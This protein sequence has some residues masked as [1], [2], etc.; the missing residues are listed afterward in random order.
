MKELL[1]RW[2]E[3][4][5]V[6]GVLFAINLI[7]RIVA[8]QISDP[9]PIELEDKQALAGFITLGAI[10]LVFFGLTVYWGRT[11]P[12]FKVATDIGFPAA[13]ACVLSVLLG[14]LLVG[15]SPFGSGAGAFF[16]QI[17]W[18][19]GLAIVGVALGFVALI[20]F[21]ADYKSKQLKRF[22]DRSKAQPRRV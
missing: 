19:G 12:A 7:G 14:P 18:W 11:R 20:S 8:K 2:R 3:G 1:L 17:W 13:A 4:L 6:T 16:S 9:S 15:D 21:T 10:F 22:A 5:I